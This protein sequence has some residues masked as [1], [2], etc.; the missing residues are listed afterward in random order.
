[1]HFIRILSSSELKGAVSNLE[2]SGKLF[3]FAKSLAFFVFNKYSRVYMEQGIYS[4]NLDL[5]KD[6]NI[7]KYL[8]GANV[9]ISTYIKYIDIFILF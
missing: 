3:C 9:V 5:N 7:C 4:T 2:N 1:M 6:N 8:G